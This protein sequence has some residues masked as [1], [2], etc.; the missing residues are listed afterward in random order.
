V[1]QELVGVVECAAQVMRGVTGLGQRGAGPN[2]DPVRNVNDQDRDDV[3]SSRDVLIGV[4]FV[5]RAMRPSRTCFSMAG[6]RGTSPEDRVRCRPIACPGGR[7]PERRVQPPAAVLR[8]GE[9]GSM[10]PLRADCNRHYEGEVA[11]GPCFVN[12]MS[13]SLLGST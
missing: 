12:G 3:M 9:F 5:R 6:R 13:K 2:N 11:K 7:I 8:L 4:R 1:G 10:L